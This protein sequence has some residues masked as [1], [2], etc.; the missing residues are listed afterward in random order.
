[1]NT[2]LHNDLPAVF[3]HSAALDNLVTLGPQA[4]SHTRADGADPRRVT[5][6]LH[7]AGRIGAFFVIRRTAPGSHR[8]GSG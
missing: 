6:R 3:L 8:A 4:L 1:M 5:A 2:P 7:P